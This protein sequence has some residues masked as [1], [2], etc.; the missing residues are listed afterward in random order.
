MTAALHFGP[1]NDSVTTTWPVRR[2]RQRFD[3]ECWAAN[4][5]T[6]L[7][8]S[9]QWGDRACGVACVAMMIDHYRNVSIPT[10]DLLRQG[11]ASGAYSPKGW[12]H[13]GLAQ[14][15]TGHGVYAQA[16]PVTVDQ[17]AD[18]VTNVGPQI[19]SVSL[20]FPTDRATKGGHLVVVTGVARHNGHLSHLSFADPSGWGATNNHITV[21]RFAHSY[22]GRAITTRSTSGTP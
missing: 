6:S 5:F 2:V 8:D 13:R 3:P 1:M 15:L 17:L 12:I 14:L 20:K 22:A 7:E 18:L 10:I 16:E 19:A 21:A 4:G 9:D 11:Q